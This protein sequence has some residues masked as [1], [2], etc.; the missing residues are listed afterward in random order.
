MTVHSFP[1]PPQPA[2]DVRRDQWGR[3]LVRPP[4]GS[5]PKGYTRVTTI[6]KALDDQGG[7]GPWK[8]TMAVCGALIR[9]GLRK[10]WETLLAVNDNDPWYAS[11][12]TKAECKRLVE[13]CAAVGGANDRREIGTALHTL[14]AMLDLG[15]RPQTLPG[16]TDRDLDAYIRG[17][18]EHSVQ[19]A[20]GHVEQ[21]VVLD[22]FSVA[23]TFD[24]V[25][26]VPGF[27]R[28]LIAD[29]KTGA[30]LT[31]SWQSIAVQLAA[32]SRAN[33]VYRQ[34]AA[35]DGS[36]DIRSAMPLVDQEHGLV[37]HL[38]AGRGRLTFHLV[39]L[40]KG[41]EAFKVAVWTR[42]WRRANVSWLL[43][44]G[45]R[46]ADLAGALEASIALHP[47]SQPPARDLVRELR[48]WLRSRITAIGAHPAARADLGARW[49]A[50]MPTLNGFAGHT[51][52]QLE[53]INR[54]LWD[55]E[56]AHTL[57]FPDPKPGEEP[58]ARV[59]RVFP[60]ATKES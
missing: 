57:T 38:P 13:E 44:D 56:R 36:E 50:G 42:E 54:V 8:A 58:I 25:A 30:D 6:A 40:T 1:V 19:I 53:E 47:S 15:Q 5:A 16:E 59:L 26:R 17:R 29:L 24:R 37:M 31:Y 22:E 46:P 23:G 49:P 4:D 27:E 51:P 43:G 39:D 2:E 3:Y 14:T 41:W 21:M 9:P 35:A 32:Y 34:G 12:T 18:S 33:S 20:A 48:G 60:N 11:K 28:P 10:Q 52:E 45:Q 7:L 55:V